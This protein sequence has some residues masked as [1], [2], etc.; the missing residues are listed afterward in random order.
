MNRATLRVAVPMSASL[1]IGISVFEEWYRDYAMPA[2]LGLG[3][4][5]PTDDEYVAGVNV[6]VTAGWSEEVPIIFPEPPEPE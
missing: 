6:V 3:V 5:D 1:D 4:R 2:S